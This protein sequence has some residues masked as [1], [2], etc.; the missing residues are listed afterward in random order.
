MEIR[1]GEKLIAQNKKF[2]EKIVMKI[3][4]GRGEAQTNK[5]TNK[6]STNKQTNKHRPRQSRKRYFL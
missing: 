1:V 2:G 6:K 4:R 3:G 5:Q